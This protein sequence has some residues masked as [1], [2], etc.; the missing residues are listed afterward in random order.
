MIRRALTAPISTIASN[1]G[2]E[3]GVA[4]HK[5]DAKSGSFGLNAL[6]GEFGDLVK[7]GVIDPTKVVRTA[8]QNAG[9]SSSM[10]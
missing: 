3:P 9:I 1:A 10:P 7:D 6:T 4:L 2:V 5:I 8:L